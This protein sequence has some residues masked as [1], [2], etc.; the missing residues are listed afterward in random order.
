MTGKRRKAFMNSASTNP[1]PFPRGTPE[2]GGRRIGMYRF[3]ALCSLPMLLIV[4][5]TGVTVIL[6]LRAIERIAASPG[7]A[8]LPEYP[9]G[10]SP[11]VPRPG[12]V[13]E[14]TREDFFG[15]KEPDTRAPDAILR[16]TWT[17]RKI[18]Y[19]SCIFLIFSIFLYS[20]A[21]HRYF[22]DPI[23]LIARNLDHLQKARPP[24]PA[25]PVRIRE[26]QWL[27]DM[28]PGLSR[29]MEELNAHSDALEMEK[30]KYVNLSMMDGLTGVGNRRSF[31]E[32]MA[33]HGA[34]C[35]LLMLDVDM[36]KLYNDTLGHQAGDTA[37]KAVAHAMKSALLRSSDQVFRYGG[38]EF[39]VILPNA[40]EEAAMSVAARILITI[41][42][43]NIPHPASSV[44]PFLTASIGVS[45]CA[46]VGRIPPRELIARADKALY[47]AKRSGRNRICVYMEGDLAPPLSRQNL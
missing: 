17:A 45:I 27:L 34:G 31:D 12:G 4:L 43:M 3:L 25:P 10:R 35:A 16:K 7:N 42:E 8:F 30:D 26:L 5:L 11:D 23:A 24:E 28:L 38:E 36:F 47:R 32:Q 14:E 9:D 20:L 40:S 46:G 22:L 19:I 37:L 41:R 39:T 15:G 44:A 33:R 1:P 21:I 18:L 6:E 29:Y 13:P 2:Q